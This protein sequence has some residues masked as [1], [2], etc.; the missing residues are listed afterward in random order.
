MI[1]GLKDDDV[2]VEEQKELLKIEYIYRKYNPS[3]K[4]SPIGHG[5]TD[6]INNKTGW[7]FDGLPIHSTT[8]AN[9]PQW[10]KYLRGKSY[11]YFNKFLKKKEMDMKRKT[12]KKH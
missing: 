4:Y 1:N 7:F 8:Y 9:S 12:I 2:N 3:S 11:I 10:F 5:A 6:I